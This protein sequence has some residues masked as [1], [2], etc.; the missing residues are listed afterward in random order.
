MG[1]KNLFKCY[2]V[3]LFISFSLYI[4]SKADSGGPLM[5][6]GQGPSTLVVGVVSTGVGCA[7]PR[8]PGV[9]TRVSDYVPWIAQ[10]SGLGR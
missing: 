9:Y 5:V 10:H 2:N 1:I 7:R 3:L 8:L 6:R 4:L